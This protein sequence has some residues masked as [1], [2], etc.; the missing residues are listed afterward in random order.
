MLRR[1][2]T[3]SELTSWSGL[4]AATLATQIL[5]SDEYAERITP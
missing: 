2:P 3:G 4:S 5:N 1:A